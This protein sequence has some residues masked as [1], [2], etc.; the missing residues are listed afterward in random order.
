MHAA[1]LSR[2]QFLSWIGGEIP[3]ATRGSPQTLARKTPPGKIFVAWRE[4]PDPIRLHHAIIAV[5]P[6]DQRDFLAFVSTYVG[7]YR[8]FTAYFRVVRADLLNE[9]L[10]AADSPQD[11]NSIFSKMAAGAALAELHMQAQAVSQPPEFTLARARGTLS[12]VAAI[13]AALGYGT[14]SLEWVEKSWVRVQQS[15]GS[16]VVTFPCADMWSAV[17]GALGSTNNSELL[18]QPSTLINDILPELQS[19]GRVRNNIL[20]RLSREFPALRGAEKQMASTREDRVRFFQAALPS[21]VDGPEDVL[22]REFAAGL[23]LATVGNGSFDH[24]SLVNGMVES[25]PRA[26][27]WFGICASLFAETNLG[28]FRGGL[29]RR[30]ARDDSRFVEFFGTPEADLSAAEFDLIYKYQDGGP[31]VPVLDVGKLSLELLPGVETLLQ[32]PQSERGKELPALRPEDVRELQFILDRARRLLGEAS[33]PRQREL[34]RS[35]SRFRKGKA[36]S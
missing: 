26:I 10:T 25:I 27:I 18:L 33:R 12:R 13:T 4:K 15:G 30:L 5:P 19:S 23:L 35:E 24:L 22:L 8:P 21:L 36:D 31:D 6:G 29:G 16:P 20:S 34:F 28:T 14:E 3:T 11:K 7:T 32:L 9:I 2:E 17:A 1:Q